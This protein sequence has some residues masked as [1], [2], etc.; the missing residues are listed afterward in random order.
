MGGY[1]HNYESASIEDLASAELIDWF[2]WD[3]LA[4]PAYARSGGD[5]KEAIALLAQAIARL[6][7]ADETTLGPKP[8]RPIGGL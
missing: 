3:N 2:V 7:E 6:A 4:V 8:T 5:R 1:G